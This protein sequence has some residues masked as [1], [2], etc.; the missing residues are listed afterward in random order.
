MNNL[1]LDQIREFQEKGS[2]LTNNA[3][4][5]A[6]ERQ[7]IEIARL[8]KKLHKE[9]ERETSNLLKRSDEYLSQKAKG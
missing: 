3:S 9:L 4:V 5:T 7:R 2:S 1:S 6:L 8:L